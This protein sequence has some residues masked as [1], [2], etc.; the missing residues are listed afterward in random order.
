MATT[1]QDLCHNYTQERL[2]LLFHET[3][4][5]AQLNPV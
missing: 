5:T 3:T 1:F 2:Q 4:I